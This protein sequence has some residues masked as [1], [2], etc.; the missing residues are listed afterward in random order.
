MYYE[1]ADSFYWAEWF[2]FITNPFNGQLEQRLYKTGDLARYLPNG[3]IE[4][5][6][7]IDNQVKIR[8]FRIELG[9]IEAVLASHP[10][11]NQAVVIAL[12]ENTGNKRLVAYSV[13]NSE[14]PT[15]ELR[16]YLKG[17]LPEY[18][19]PSAFET[20]ERLPLTPNGKIDHKALPA[21]GSE[22]ENEYV[23]AR[24][25]VEQILTHIWEELL[26]VNKIS[27]HDNFFEIGG[28]SILSI[29]V[30]SRAKNAGIQITAKQ[31]FQ[32]QTIAEVATV[33]NTIASY[34][35]F[36]GIVTGVAPLTPIQHF[37][38]EE[39]TEELHHYNQSV[40][41]QTPKN[42]KPSL[43]EKAVEKLQNDVE[44]LKD[45]QRSFSN[46]DQ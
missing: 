14:I 34:K 28:D 2:R 31:I 8:G 44:K 39:Q 10:Q 16:E 12:E 21:P 15:K 20:L 11:I 45:K 32:Y 26:P 40:L 6:G 24:T 5:L 22:R 4:Y 13:A 41:L 29:Q 33:A 27:I 37:F 9:E 46:G 43:L 23:A 30:I 17:Q 3:D 36:Q 38:F 18:M 35:C 7:R 42:I 1:K 19:V 25:E